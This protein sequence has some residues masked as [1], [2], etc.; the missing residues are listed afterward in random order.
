MHWPPPKRLSP[1]PGKRGAKNISRACNG[2]A[3]KLCIIA[4]IKAIEGAVNGSITLRG[5]ASAKSVLAR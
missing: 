3:P 5:R 1:T 4:S 2:S